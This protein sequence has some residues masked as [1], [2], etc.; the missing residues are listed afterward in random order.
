[1]RFLSSV[2]GNVMLDQSVFKEWRQS[3]NMWS[4]QK[5]TWKH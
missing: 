1:M 2:A 4:E 3:F 5:S